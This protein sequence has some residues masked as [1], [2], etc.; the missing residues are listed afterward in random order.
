MIKPTFIT[1]LK[2]DFSIYDLISF[3]DKTKKINKLDLIRPS[4]NLK[5]QLQEDKY[6]NSLSF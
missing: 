1:E 3:S 6:K 4:D 2:T 5:F